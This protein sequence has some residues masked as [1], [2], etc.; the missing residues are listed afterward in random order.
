MKGTNSGKLMK[1]NFTFQMNMSGTILRH[2]CDLFSCLFINNDP[3]YRLGYELEDRGSFISQQGQWWDFF[4]FITASRSDLG[5]NQP[6]IKWI[7]ETYTPGVKR[8]ERE[9]DHL[10]IMPMLKNAWCYT[11]TPQYVFVMW[12]FVNHKDK[13]TS[14]ITYKFW[15]L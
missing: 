14:Y 8:P 6:P 4:L 1:S 11:C 13:F 7:P 9:D 10:H 3:L 2:V 12:C 15:I 5:P